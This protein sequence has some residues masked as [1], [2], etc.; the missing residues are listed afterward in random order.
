MDDV[1]KMYEKLTNELALVGPVR[2]SGW[3]MGED[4]M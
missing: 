4:N 1:V 2:F 3:V